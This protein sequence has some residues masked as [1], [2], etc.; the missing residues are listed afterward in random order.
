MFQ[1]RANADGNQTF[2]NFEFGHSCSPHGGQYFI[3]QC[4]SDKHKYTLCTRVT[5]FQFDSH[6]IINASVDVTLLVRAVFSFHFVAMS[7]CIVNIFDVDV[8]S[9]RNNILFKLFILW[10]EARAYGSSDGKRSPLPM[11]FVNI[12]YL[13]RYCQPLGNLWRCPFIINRRW[14]IL[15][16]KV[17]RPPAT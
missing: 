16:R 3:V 17:G 15:A 11:V 4:S 10:R 1:S 5:V 7:R 9:K 12:D 2:F 13:R 14:P 6:T 8:R